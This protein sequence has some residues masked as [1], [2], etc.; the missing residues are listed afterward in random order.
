[1]AFCPRLWDT[2]WHLLSLSRRE[3]DNLHARHNGM[4]GDQKR[5][6]APDPFLLGSLSVPIDPEAH[7][8][9][10]EGTGNNGSDCRAPSSQPQD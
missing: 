9:P 4:L 1:M 3:T 5:E 6:A 8:Q 2:G 10:L 7:P